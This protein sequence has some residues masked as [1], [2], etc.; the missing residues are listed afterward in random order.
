MKELIQR[1]M[2][3]YMKKEYS[4]SSSSKYLEETKTNNNV[5]YNNIDSKESNTLNEKLLL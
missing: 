5:N 3:I 2:K 4:N 1:T